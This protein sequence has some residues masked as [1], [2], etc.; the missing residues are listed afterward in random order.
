M[1][2]TTY[3]LSWLQQQAELA[4]SKEAWDEAKE[5]WAQYYIEKAKHE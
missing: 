2:G 1:I 4:D 5:Y 3:Y